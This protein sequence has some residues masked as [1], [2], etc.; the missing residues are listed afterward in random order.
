[1]KSNTLVRKNKRTLA[2]VKSDIDMT[3]LYIRAKKGSG[4]PVLETITSR[5]AK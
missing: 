3:I 2:Q 1:M 5:F 4:I